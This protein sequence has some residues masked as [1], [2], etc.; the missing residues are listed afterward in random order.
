M[1]LEVPPRDLP[2]LDPARAGDAEQAR[3]PAARRRGAAER[4]VRA[5]SSRAEA[6][7]DRER[8]DDCAD[9]EDERGGN[10]GATDARGD[11]HPRHDPIDHVR[12]G[13]RDQGHNRQRE[14]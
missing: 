2:V 4:A 8:D 1:V 5:R 10:G 6:S 12:R 13:G 9:G 7:G 14:A 3:V 11:M